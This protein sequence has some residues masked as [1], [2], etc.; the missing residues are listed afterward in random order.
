MKTNKERAL[1]ARAALLAH[2]LE[3]CHGRKVQAHAELAADPAAVLR[4]LLA[5]LRHWCDREGIAF[6]EQ[7]GKAASLYR[8]EIE[9]A[10]K[11]E[12]EKG[13]GT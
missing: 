2:Q 4:Y 1:R 9:E 13:G 3:D 10:R 5:D 11:A 8:E 6:H 7:D 12:R